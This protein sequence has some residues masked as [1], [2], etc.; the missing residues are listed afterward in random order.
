MRLAYQG[1]LCRSGRNINSTRSTLAR[2]TWILHLNRPYK[3]LKLGGELHLE[4]EK[5]FADFLGF[6]GL[7]SCALDD[8]LGIWWSVSEEERSQV[9]Q[10]PTKFLETLR[11]N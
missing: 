6:L 8:F 10:K 2:V 5:N 4:M 9:S 11:E 7:G 1:S 3:C